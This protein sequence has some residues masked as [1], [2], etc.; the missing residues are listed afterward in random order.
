MDEIVAANTNGILVNK[1]SNNI[2]L[3]MLRI[4][5]IIL[6]LSCNS[7]PLFSQEEF[8][9]PFP[10]WA[11]V[12]TRFGAIGDGKH[13]DTRAIQNAID[14][15]TV[16]PMGFNIGKDAYSVVYIPAGTYVI[17]S[18]LLLKG[19]IGCSIIGFDPEKT[20]IVWKGGD[21]DT[22][23]LASG[24]AY[25]KV[26]RISW[27]ASGKKQMECI[28]L[29]WMEKWK[30]KTSMSFATVNIEFS[31]L[32]F[33][34]KPDFGIF[35]GTVGG[36]GVKGTGSND[37]EVTIKRCFFSECSQAGIKIA[38][39][40]AL[41]YWIWDSK[42]L[43]CQIG[44]WNNSGNYHA[45]KCL[46]IKSTFAD[47]INRNSYYTS[48]RGCFSFESQAF[49]GDDGSSCNPFKRIFQGNK[50]IRTKGMPIQ[51]YH[52]GRITLFDNLITKSLDTLHPFLVNQKS[53]CP[54]S[55]SMLSIGNSYG[56]AKQPLRIAN[57]GGKIFS[58]SDQLIINSIPDVADF[59]KKMAV[60]PTIVT[61]KI[62]EVPF[63]AT[64]E[65]IQV[66]INQAAKISG[67]R[68]IIHFPTGIFNIN[69]TISIP[70]GSDMQLCGDGLFNASVIRGVND[71]AFFRIYGPSYITMHDLEVGQFSSKQSSNSIFVFNNVD[72]PG[73]HAFIDE[74]Y[75]IS[76][77]TITM[78]KLNFLLVQKTNS[79]FADGDRVIGGDLVSS[80][81]GSAALWAFG[82][83]FA[84]VSVDN[85]GSFIA[86]D[87]WWEGNQRVPVDLKGKGNLSLDG[88]MMAPSKADSNPTIRVS[89]FNGRVSIMNGY[90]Q[91]GLQ[92]DPV[93]EQLK[94]LAWNLHFYHKMQPD[95]SIPRNTKAKIAFMGNTVQCFIKGDKQCEN[96]TSVADVL[97]N[98]E[99]QA[100]F[101]PEM[102]ADDRLAMPINIKG[103]N[104]GVSNILIYRVSMGNSQSA[105][106]FR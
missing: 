81:K 28:G 17:S 57:E 39:Y 9:G 80:G 49:S 88:I 45:Y 55:Y 100:I 6:I 68:P 77:N 72:Q 74:V 21:I 62:F 14:S 78:D 8:N 70:A 16:A 92:I 26:S 51:Y 24:S 84:N 18:T 31:D 104:K 25:F 43:N 73:S 90:I 30:D 35:G 63:Q 36:G 64:T 3:L 75:S 99:D 97:V 58:Y 10:S 86:K 61:R 42:F 103:Y 94:M 5:G 12:K 41:D 91:G 76:P 69:K 53:W 37:S 13:D 40:N 67:K 29:H 65:Q 4:L 106:V 19:K 44:V 48:V 38:G 66:I 20:R 27:D 60:T 46:F 32:K 87:C 50:V 2:N 15:L 79:F 95:R 34:G 96:P 7:S 59:E 56:Y 83:Q 101:L 23:L 82:A 102:T 85:G 98:I 54:V 89:S 22:M 1:K 105:I 33:F 11:N 93:N 47:F 52:V 71:S